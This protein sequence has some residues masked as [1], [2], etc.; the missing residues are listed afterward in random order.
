MSDESAYRL[1]EHINDV[2]DNEN[3]REQISYAATF[4]CVLRKQNR[5]LTES[6]DKKVAQYFPNYYNGIYKLETTLNDSQEP[7]SFVKKYIADIKR[8]NETQ[9]KNGAYFGHG[10]REIATVKSILTSQ[11]LIR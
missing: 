10:T 1:V 9:G 4:L 7:L 3:E 5:T 2:L 11:S 6:M 8:S